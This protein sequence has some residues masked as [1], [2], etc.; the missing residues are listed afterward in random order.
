MATR[1]RFHSWSPDRDRTR[2][3]HLTLVVPSEHGKVVPTWNYTAVHLT[4]TVRVHHEPE[5][6]LQ[7]VTDLTDTHEQPRPQPWHVTDAPADYIA[8]Q[9]RA[10]V[11]IELDIDHVEAKAKLSQNRATPD[12]IG[13]IQGLRNEQQPGGMATAAAMEHEVQRAADQATSSPMD[14]IVYYRPRS[15]RRPRKPS[16]TDRPPLH[17]ARSGDGHSRHRSE[18][19][20]RRLHDFQAFSCGSA[21]LGAER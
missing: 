4:G 19:G 6:L 7:V 5:W 10:I 14:P 13:V 8:S 20:H 9:L 17:T 11:G 15:T 12:Q 18:A 21:H 3:V 1:R 16:A 2:R